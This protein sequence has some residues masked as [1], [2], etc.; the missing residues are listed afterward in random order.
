M[1]VEKEG[2][3]VRS[4]D[5]T[6]RLCPAKKISQSLIQPQLASFSTEAPVKHHFTSAGQGVWSQEMM[7][8]ER[9]YILYGVYFAVLHSSLT[10]RLFGSGTE[11]FTCILRPSCLLM[12]TQV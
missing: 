8:H 4:L 10:C 9:Y 11:M 7:W 3:G 1:F 5:K 6:K 12:T 2:L